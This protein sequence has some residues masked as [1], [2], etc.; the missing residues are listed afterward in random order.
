[1]RFHSWCYEGRSLD[2]TTVLA[3]ENAI[4]CTFTMLRICPNIVINSL[5]LV[6]WINLH[7]FQI[8]ISQSETEQVVCIQSLRICVI[9]KLLRKLFGEPGNLEAAREDFSNIFQM[10]RAALRG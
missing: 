9:L 3:H 8:F 10:H 2:I 4:G 7:D 5:R 1:M 6:F